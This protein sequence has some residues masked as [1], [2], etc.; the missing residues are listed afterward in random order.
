MLYVD[1]P[2]G[3]LVTGPLSRMG[4]TYDPAPSVA[5]ARAK[6]WWKVERAHPLLAT[7]LE[8]SLGRRMRE[9]PLW[10]DAAMAV[11]VAPRS[12]DVVAATLE[13]DL[14]LLDQELLVRRPEAIVVNAQLGASLEGLQTLAQVRWAE[15]AAGVGA[16]TAAPL[17]RA[18]EHE[19]Y[20][21]LVDA[22]LSTPAAV[23]DVVAAM[24]A[25]HGRPFDLGDPGCGRWIAER[26]GRYAMHVDDDRDVVRTFRELGAEA[27]ATAR[28]Y[29]DA[30]PDVAQAWHAVATGY[31]GADAPGR[32]ALNADLQARARVREFAYRTSPGATAWRQGM[33]WELQEHLRRNDGDLAW[34]LANPDEGRS[35]IERLWR[36]ALSARQ[37]GTHDAVIAA[38]RARSQEL[39]AGI[40]DGPLRV[41]HA[42]AAAT[43]GPSGW[44]AHEAIVQG[45]LQHDPLAAWGMREEASV[46]GQP[47]T[48]VDA[49]LRQGRFD[50]TTG[51]SR[52]PSS[53]RRPGSRGRSIF[54]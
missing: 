50:G 21:P 10:S 49:L 14:D 8:R 54:G 27:L 26:L 1:L 23:R 13:R 24:S 17:W 22:V 4:T 35:E 45:V 41:C 19:A 52:T 32:V 44:V 53:R 28:E 11:V 34:E 29:G 6:G 42:R 38:A 40:T 5:E 12:S 46:L 2:T 3:F 30:A 20:H 47:T 51:A 36:E 43:R 39:L 9:F 31:F 25:L 48:D 15:A 16:P 37:D 18:V 33:S 7:M